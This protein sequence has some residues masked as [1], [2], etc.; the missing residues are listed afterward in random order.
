M[1][2]DFVPKL[3]GQAEYEKVRKHDANEGL[4][5]IVHATATKIARNHKA[6]IMREIKR[7]EEAELLKKRQER[8][9]IEATKLR[10]ERRNALRE[11]Y[12]LRKLTN[13]FMNNVVHVAQ[14]TE[15]SPALTV[16]DVREYHPSRENGVFVIGGFVG[17]LLIVFTALYDYMLSNPANAEFK[18]SN[19]AIEKFLVDWMKEADFPEGTC[20]VKLK[21]ELQF[22][23]ADDNGVL[24]V[25]VT[26]SQFANAL[27]NPAS[28]Q[29]FG[30]KFML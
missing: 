16:Y 30:L 11:A 18:F 4:N 1:G 7:L 2:I 24:D 17:E 21:E 22:K 10:K 28:H 6:S 29:S 19:E 23:V 8:E 5:D 27:K 15:Y 25:G 9:R 3:V 13:N 20:V 14:R 12:A 26:A